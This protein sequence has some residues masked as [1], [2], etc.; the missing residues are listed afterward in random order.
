MAVLAGDVI[1]AARDRHAAFDRQRHPN[2][3]ALRYLSGYVKALRGKIMAIDP[4]MVRVELPVV[5]PLANHDAGIALPAG[6]L[7]V[8]EVAGTF[9]KQPQPPWPIPIIDITAR[10]A[11]NAPTGAAWQQGSTLFLRGP[12][13]LWRDFASV[14]LYL[15]A[16]PLTLTELD[17]PL[18]IPDA[19][20]LACTE[21]CALFFAGREVQEA[22]E[23]KISL[24]KFV[25]TAAGAESDYLDTV[26]AGL[27]GKVFVTQDVWRP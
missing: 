18:A 25:G 12:D 2:K 23:S 22:S 9:L 26:K 10:F 4:A 16:T 13:T 27:A 1:D 8:D 17:D 3:G 19:A 20:E 24:Q 15:V 21:A 6:T 7:L 14:T 11:P 5:L